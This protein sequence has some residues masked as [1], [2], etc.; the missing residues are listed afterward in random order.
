MSKKIKLDKQNFNKHTP[1]G[2]E[3]LEKSIKENNLPFYIK[4][5]LAKLKKITL[6]KIERDKDYFNL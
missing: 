1:E 3:L 4:D 6:S 2:M 5:D